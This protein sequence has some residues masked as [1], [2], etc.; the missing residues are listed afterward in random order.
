MVKK[1]CIEDNSIRDFEFVY[2]TITEARVSCAIKQK[3]S[4]LGSND[5]GDV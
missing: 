2:L 5:D 1:Y 3:S 4:I